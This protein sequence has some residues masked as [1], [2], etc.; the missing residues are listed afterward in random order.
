MKKDTDANVKRF[1]ARLMVKG[2]AQKP[3]INFDE[4]FLSVVHLTTVRIVLVIT[5]VMDLELE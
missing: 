3:K 4:I 1:K 2:Y 5:V